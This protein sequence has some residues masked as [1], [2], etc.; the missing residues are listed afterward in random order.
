MVDLISSEYTNT[1]GYFLVHSRS[2]VKSRTGKS[3]NFIRLNQIDSTLDRIDEVFKLEIETYHKIQGKISGNT[4]LVS[5]V[6]GDY[7]SHKHVLYIFNI[8]DANY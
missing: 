7:S 3:V 1:Y 5:V 4:L 2:Q 8:K 6:E